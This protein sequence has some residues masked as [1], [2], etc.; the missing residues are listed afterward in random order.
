MTQPR[1]VM[2][3]CQC[4]REF[5]TSIAGPGRPSEFC[6]PKCRA[7]ARR[8]AHRPIL[9]KVCAVCGEKF[10]STDLRTQCCGVECGAA[11]AKHKGDAAR[12]ANARE[13]RRRV[14]LACSQE[15][16][17][18]NPS[19]AARRGESNEGVFCGRKCAAV[20]RRRRPA[21]QGDLFEAAPCR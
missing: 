15:F 3:R 17:M 12:M 1:V 14:C 7:T 9:R 19:G 8:N 20:W 10:E 2:K 16:T 13:R 4:D 5:A 11:L 21:T 6:S 18:R